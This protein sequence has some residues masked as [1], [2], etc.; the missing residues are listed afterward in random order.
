MM[1]TIG[2]DN[3]TGTRITAEFGKTVFGNWVT[4]NPGGESE[5]YFIYKL[6]P[7][8]GHL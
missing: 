4:T 5:I 1:F 3:K 8:N 7:K 6:Y 2:I